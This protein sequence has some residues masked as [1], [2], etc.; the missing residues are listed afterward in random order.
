M[1]PA[2]SESQRRL[3]CAALS[4]KLGDTAGKENTQANEMAKSMSEEELR[5]YCESPVKGSK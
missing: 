2:K 5:K 3:A 1:S 4:I